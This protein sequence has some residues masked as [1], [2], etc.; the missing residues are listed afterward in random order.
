MGFVQRDIY[1]NYCRYAVKMEE[2]AKFAYTTKSKWYAKYCRY[3]EWAQCIVYHFLR[4]WPK[5]RIIEIVHVLIN[6]I[7]KFLNLSHH[8][9][10]VFVIHHERL[11]HG[12][13]GCPDI[14][15]SMFHDT[16]PKNYHISSQVPVSLKLRF[17]NSHAVLKSLFPKGDIRTRL[18]LWCVL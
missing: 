2:Y 5:D 10:F 15:A 11:F 12:F 3:V 1:T 17:Q 7:A 6:L 9:F 13:Y 18:L 16:S 14:F 4:A 8:H